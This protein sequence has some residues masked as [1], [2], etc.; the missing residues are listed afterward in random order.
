[1]LS[2]AII[3]L[4]TAAIAFTAG[5]SE[6]SLSAPTAVFGLM[7]GGYLLTAML[8]AIDAD[9]L[10][11][12]LLWICLSVAVMYWGTLAAHPFS[13]SY[14]VAGELD[15]GRRLVVVQ[16]LRLVASAAL[17]LG[18]GVFV[19]ILLGHGLTARDLLSWAIITQVSSEGRLARQSGDLETSVGTRLVYSALMLGCAYGGMLFRMTRKQLDRG[20]AAGTLAII[21]AI[22]TVYGSRM[23]V[24]YGG[25]FW[26]ASYLAAH[27]YLTGARRGSDRSLIYIGVATVFILAGLST[28]QMVIRYAA[29]DE[30]DWLRILADPVAFVAA[31]GVWFDKIG[32]HANGLMYGGRLLR[33][34]F[35]LIGFSYELPPAIP[36]AFTSSNI[37]T[38]FRDLIEDLG[39]VGALGFMFFFGF[40]GRVVFANVA[41]GRAAAVPWLAF[42]YAFALTSFASGMLSYTTSTLAIVVFVA[43]YGFID[44]PAR[45]TGSVVHAAK[46]TPG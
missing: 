4:T 30:V 40:G 17:L 42:I 2:I 26:V 3:A 21:T 5:R 46:P 7:W 10:I 6:R 27:V 39:T 38:V 37:Y 43:T 8:F 25:S 28:M 9:R 1:M 34:A 33:R 14:P 18:L 15:E 13:P 22:Y 45:A 31:F 44:A 29:T 19:N 41:L 23:G 24:L 20:I 32:F 35:E 11:G 16:R 36:I 12:G